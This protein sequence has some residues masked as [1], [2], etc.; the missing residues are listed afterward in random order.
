MEK[1]TILS[2]PS[3]SPLNSH[4]LI[5]GKIV[6]N[7]YYYQ[8]DHQHGLISIDFMENGKYML[9]FRIEKIKK[10]IQS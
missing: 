4:D 10:S 1:S 3:P 7:D 5:N 2:P 6:N 8:D 9:K